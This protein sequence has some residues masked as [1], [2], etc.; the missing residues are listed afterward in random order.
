[1][2][3]ANFWVVCWDAYYTQYLDEQNQYPRL[4][5]Y[6]FSF[7]K[8]DKIKYRREFNSEV[9]DPAP[10]KWRHLFC[11][12][13]HAQQVL[14]SAGSR[15]RLPEEKPDPFSE[16]PPYGDFLKENKNYRPYLISEDGQS[17]VTIHD[18]LEPGWSFPK[19]QG[20]AVYSYFID[21]GDALH[22]YRILASSLFVENYRNSH[23]S[24]STGIAC[25]KVF[26]TLE[27]GKFSLDRFSRFIGESGYEFDLSPSEFGPLLR[28]V[29]D[30][31]LQWQG[32]ELEK[33][34]IDDEQAA[35]LID[36]NFLRDRF[37]QDRMELPKVRY[38]L[39]YGELYLAMETLAGSGCAGRHRLIGKVWRQND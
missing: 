22:G 16:S 26:E 5:S 12:R 39:D 1:M 28:D 20:S 24:I 38:L 3:G 27:D 19:G 34:S 13:E 31:F 35:A 30:A 23:V 37:K 29:G 17:V 15:I 7:P 2:F 10:A 25:M 14:D 4:T 32:I 6:K 18:Y 21:C 11:S 9:N 33:L 36:N 8:K